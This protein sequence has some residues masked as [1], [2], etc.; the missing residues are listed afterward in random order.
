MPSSREGRLKMAG[1]WITV[2]APNKEIWRVHDDDFEKLKTAY[3][4]VN[5]LC[6]KPEGERSQADNAEIRAATDALVAC[7]RDI[8]KR[9][10]YTPPLTEADFLRLG[11]KPKDTTPTPVPAPTG[12]AEVKTGYA[13]P[14][15]LYAFVSHL[16][17]TAFD[18]KT[19]HGYKLAF[20]LCD[21]GQTPPASGK[22]FT[23]TKFSRKKKFLFS[24][25]PEDKGK[26]MYFAVRYEN[27]KG[28]AG[29]WGP[30]TEAVVP[31]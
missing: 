21:A 18:P 9:S 30:V 8:K 7:M 19:V 20:K 28:D 10:F 4:A 14:A 22:E 25:E 29:P 2:I 27:S 1:D 6:L 17:G 23:E 13:G 31:F 26:K 15:Q 12:Q 11:L 3:A 16:E 24:L 5:T